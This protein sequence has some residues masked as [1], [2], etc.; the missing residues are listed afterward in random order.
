MHLVGFIIRSLQY[1]CF[2]LLNVVFEKEPFS[3]DCTAVQL[4]YYTS[5]SHI[6]PWD[7]HFYSIS[8][9]TVSC[10][11][12]R[13]CHKDFDI[14]YPLYIYGCQFSFSPEQKTGNKHSAT[15]SSDI[16][17]ISLRCYLVNYI[18][19]DRFCY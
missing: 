4:I 13:S 14:S 6:M 10:V 19:L 17:T 7:E 8:I 3:L 2:G 18:S 9:E 11:F 5:K 12:N 1:S 16:I 15:N